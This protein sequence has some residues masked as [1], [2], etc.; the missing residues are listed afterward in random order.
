MCAL[1][2]QISNRTVVVVT[3]IYNS[4]KR[5]KNHLSAHR[6]LGVAFAAVLYLLC[7]TGT[8]LVFSNE[9]ERWEHPGVEEFTQLDATAIARAYEHGMQRVN[10]ELTT[11]WVVLPTPSLP[12]AHVS[13]GGQ[14]WHLDNQGNL[15]D[16]PT[17]PWL[18]M[19]I[20]LHYY[21]HLPENF[22]MIV[23]AI[24]GVILLSLSISGV[25]AHPSIIKDAFK[26]RRGKSE[27]I[28]HTDLHNR[29][30]VWGLPFNVMIAITGAFIGLF[31]VFLAFSAP[32]FYDNNSAKIIEKIYGKDIQITDQAE[33]FNI[34]SMLNEL[35]IRVPEANPIYFAFQHPGTDKQYV[36]IAATL[37]GR[38]IYSEIYR[39]EASGKFI[40]DQALA[41]GPVGREVAYSVYRLHF[42]AF[43]G[44]TIKILYLIFGLALCNVCISGVNI[45]FSRQ[46]HQS[47]LN[48]LWRAVTWGSP[49]AL[50][51]S[52]LFVNTGIFTNPT[53][54]FWI[55]LTSIL[56][57]S[58]A[59]KNTH[60]LCG[61]LKT[62][63]GLCLLLLAI[64]NLLDKNQGFNEFFLIFNSILGIIGV[65]FLVPEEK[66]IYVSKFT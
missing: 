61:Y 62:S 21:L 10:S 28:E 8:L 59:V 22:D 53:R 34:Q 37:P 44:L 14:E 16:K 64:N 7:L 2:G 63:L 56:L 25:L 41:D 9:I 35:H 29:L 6:W 12:R 36:E 52:A 30:G 18:D 4:N 45:W 54:V 32:L 49:L 20:H 46:N 66:K 60:N 15:L 40:N 27:R 11:F 50:A 48:Q 43:G 51:L 24:F 47:M 55:A 33:I 5:I 65:Y 17:V 1:A 57:T 42:G 38:L 23:V 19:L 58:G 3:M 39:F 31:S 13:A 26:Y